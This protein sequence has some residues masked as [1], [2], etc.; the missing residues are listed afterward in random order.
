MSYNNKKILRPRQDV[1]DTNTVFRHRP[2]SNANT[3]II[4]TQGFGK[5]HYSFASSF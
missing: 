3:T 5:T 4:D 2:N 1:S